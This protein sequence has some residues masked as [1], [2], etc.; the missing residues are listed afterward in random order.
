MLARGARPEFK[1]CQNMVL[2]YTISTEG[3]YCFKCF[4]RPIFVNIPG[5]FFINSGRG[6]IT[7]YHKLK[8]SFSIFDIVNNRP[9]VKMALYP[10]LYMYQT[11]Q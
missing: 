4:D 6:L 7:E 3:F 8:M 11:Y 2:P 10:G 1:M 9:N 5:T